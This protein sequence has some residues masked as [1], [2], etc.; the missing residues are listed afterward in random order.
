[1]SLYVYETKRLYTDG[2]HHF[3]AESPEE[4]LEY[5]RDFDSE[6]IEECRPGVTI[7]VCMRG[8]EVCEHGGGKSIE[9]TAAEFVKDRKCGYAFSMEE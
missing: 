1:M 7:H 6:I 5:S 4:A 3:V 9:L 8:G 2:N